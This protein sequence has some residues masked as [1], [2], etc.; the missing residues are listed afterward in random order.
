LADPDLAR[1]LGD[2]G[3]RVAQRRFGIHRFVADWD[4]TLQAVTS[5]GA[6][7]LSSPAG[8]SPP[9]AALAEATA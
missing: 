9:D 1:A 8:V 5:G 3:R 7:G 6:G 2:E 4:Q